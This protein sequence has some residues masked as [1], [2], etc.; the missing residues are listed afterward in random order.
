M[1][2]A[3]GRKVAG[4]AGGGGL[5]GT[6]LKRAGADRRGHVTGVGDPGDSER[7]GAHATSL[8]WLGQ[9]ASPSARQPM[10]TGRASPA[11]FAE[12]TSTKSHAGVSQG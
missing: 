10:R 3:E 5:V 8:C 12:K 11:V 1:G 7:A 9:P 2:A 6:A 4:A